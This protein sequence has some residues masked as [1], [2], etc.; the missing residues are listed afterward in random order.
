MTDLLT[1]AELDTELINLANET[2][3][4]IPLSNPAKR[5]VALL[6]R[7]AYILGEDQGKARVNAAIDSLMGARLESEKVQSLFRSMAT[8]ER[9]CKAQGARTPNE[10]LRSYSAGPTLKVGPSE[11][12][13][14]TCYGG[15]TQ[16]HFFGADQADAMAQMAQ[17]AEGDMLPEARS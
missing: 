2:F 17:W 15:M 9:W 16:H 12:F 8:I 4:E 1:T 7:A 6:T 13:R 5:C 10:A 14:V 11:Q 3:R